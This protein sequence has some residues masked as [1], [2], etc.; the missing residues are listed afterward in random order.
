[1]PVAARELRGLVD[2]LICLRQPDPL[3]AVGLHYSD[4]SQL[5]DS[6]VLALLAEDAARDTA[7]KRDAW[8]RC[9]GSDPG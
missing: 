4:F 7:V 3:H 6:D 2:H 8:G 1:M 5:E 9:G